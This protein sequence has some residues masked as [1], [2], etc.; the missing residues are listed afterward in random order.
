[1]AQ[2]K[3]FEKRE[4]V[5]SDGHGYSRSQRRPQ[6]FWARRDT[7]WLST[8]S[9]DFAVLLMYLGR[10]GAWLECYSII[11]HHEVE[12]LT[13]RPARPVTLELIQIRLSEINSANLPIGGARL[14]YMV[15]APLLLPAPGLLPL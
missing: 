4:M 1:M 7:K 14:P 5:R 15:S 3:D 10:M 11:R 12:I 6:E 8:A 2:N 13:R 9:P